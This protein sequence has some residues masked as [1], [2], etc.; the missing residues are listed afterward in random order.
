MP[1]CLRMMAF[2]IG[3]NQQIFSSERLWF[4]QFIIDD[5]GLIHEMNSD[6][7][8]LQYVHELPSTPERALERLQ[9]S[10]LPHYTLYGYGRWAV[11]LKE[12]NDFIGWCGLKYR[13]ERD[14][15]DLGYRFIRA[16][17]GK[18][19]AMEAALASLN[20]GFNDLQIQRITA[21]AHIKNTASL[22]IIKKCGMRYLYDTEIDQCP[23]K[24]FE[25][26]KG[27]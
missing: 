6:P 12:N 18:G 5:A 3:M 25:R 22:N 19:Y 23:V 10:I 7:L 17:W 4:R 13:P 8:V 26:K 14:E 21:A 16:Y 15:T 9:K 24:Y 11:H 2:F 1:S 27:E 20:Y